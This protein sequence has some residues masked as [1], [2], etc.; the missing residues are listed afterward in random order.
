M[1]DIK[2]EKSTAKIKTPQVKGSLAKGAGIG[3]KMLTEIVENTHSNSKQ[4]H[5]NGVKKKEK[6]VS[7]TSHT[8]ANVNWATIANKITVPNVVKGGLTLGTGY[9]GSLVG[10]GLTTGIGFALGG[11]AGAVVGYHI[12]NV[13]GFGVGAVGGH[14]FGKVV[15]NELEDKEQD[16]IVKKGSTIIN[17][18]TET[19]ADIKKGDR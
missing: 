17:V 3:S 7:I 18:D 9:L 5:A 4:K 1:V 16:D 10:A 6:K 15:A 11:P 12:G 14:K 13:G 2:D 19:K 8:E